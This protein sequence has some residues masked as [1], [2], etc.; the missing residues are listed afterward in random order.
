MKLG[1]TAMSALCFGLGLTTPVTVEAVPVTFQVNLAVQTTLGAFT[2]GTDAVEVHGSFNNWGPGTA[3][4][5]GDS[6]PSIY[7]GALDV[8]AASGS[9]VQ[10][11]FVINR[12]GA[13]VWEN[14]G[15][16]PGGQQ[17][18]V[19]T[20]TTTA[21][22]LPVVYFNNQ[23]T[24]PGVTAVTF[25]VNL[26]VQQAAGNFDPAL[27]T[28]ECHGSFDSWGAGVP[29]SP[30]QD[31]TNV[32]LGTANVTGSPGAVIEYKF[33]I[34]RAGSLFWEGNVG[35]GGPNGNRTLTLVA[36]SQE[37]PVVYFSNLTNNPGAGIS[38]TFLV[39]MA[40]LTARGTFDPSTGTV[41]V[42]GP[43][44]NWGSPSGF[45]L[46]NSPANPTLFAGT[47]R[48]A[49]ASPGNSIPY[50]FTMNGTWEMGDNRSFILASSAQTL[51]VDYFDRVSDFGP[52][53]IETTP[54]IVTLSW[55]PGVLIRL[56]STTSVTNRVWDDVPDTLGQA[57]A[58]VFNDTFVAGAMFFRLT[59]P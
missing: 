36:G 12:G 32:Y 25:Q 2:P 54:F 55:T 23:T 5:P 52:I 27:H 30:R 49:T 11:K 9:Q 31:N 15:V 39:S 16:G 10:Y 44:N 42:R 37:L 34:N 7:E 8:S 19:F 47:I 57:S 46:T 28:V 20:N 56:Q 33:V 17:N 40:V 1:I 6:D 13:L 18:R 43:F 51:P 14:D 4:A 24:P 38:V 53:T 59:G 48:V 26:E 50:K 45:I 58:V 35:P 41:D 21:Q 22:T 3:L 29:L